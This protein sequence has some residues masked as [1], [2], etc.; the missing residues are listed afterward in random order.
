MTN[1]EKAIEIANNN[2]TH[3]HC[4]HGEHYFTSVGDCYR[5]AKEM[6]AWKDEQF[7]EQNK[8]HKVADD[9]VGSPLQDYDGQ[10]WVLCQFQDNRDGYLYMPH[11]AEW[12]RTDNCWHTIESDNWESVYDVL[13]KCIAWCEIPKYIKM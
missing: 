7:A 12:N 6:A 3:A 2:C 13:G 10:D 11:I 1:E 5:A 9:K 8:W 4:S